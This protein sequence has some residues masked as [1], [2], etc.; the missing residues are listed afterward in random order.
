MK[1]IQFK[2]NAFEQSM[3]PL[4]ATKGEVVLRHATGFCCALIEIP[5]EAW[6]QMTNHQIIDRY[7]VP[8][9]FEVVQSIRNRRK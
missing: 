2:P 8:G 7:V 6:S 9:A 3:D 5:N 1:D 4:T